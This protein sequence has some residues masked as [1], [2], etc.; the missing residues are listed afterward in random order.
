ML[1]FRG[2]A[3]GGLIY[4]FVIQ[5]ISEK[6]HYVAKVLLTIWE[7]FYMKINVTI[8]MWPTDLV[9]SSLLSFFLS[10][11]TNQRQESGFPHVGGLVTRNISAFCL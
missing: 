8:I 10:Y 4:S 5:V 7:R 9:I 2:F 1:S 6:K 3:E 11:V